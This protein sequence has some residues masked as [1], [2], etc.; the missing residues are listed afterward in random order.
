MSFEATNLFG[1]ISK[2]TAS[3]PSL[4]S[5]PSCFS[6]P[7]TLA[8]PASDLPPHPTD[9]ASP[10]NLRF[11]QLYTSPEYDRYRSQLIEPPPDALEAPA[12]RDDAKSP[13]PMD[14]SGHSFSPLVCAAVQEAKQVVWASTPAKDGLLSRPSLPLRSAV[15]VPVCSI[16]KEVVLLLMFSPAV[17]ELTEEAHR[18]LYTVAQAASDAVCGFLPASVASSLVTS[19]ARGPRSPLPDPT[20]PG[21]NNMPHTRTLIEAL[22]ASVTFQMVEMASEM[23]GVNVPIK[24]EFLE[25]FNSIYNPP[26][27]PLMPVAGEDGQ[28][29]EEG[30]DL[31]AFDSLPPLEDCFLPTELLE[32]GV[33]V[34]GLRD[35]EMTGEDWDFGAA[36]DF[37]F[38]KDQGGEELGVGTEGEWFGPGKGREGGEVLNWGMTE[39]GL[40]DRLSQHTEA[41]QPSGMDDNQSNVKQEEGGLQ[42]K[43]SDREQGEDSVIRFFYEDA[44]QRLRFEEFVKGFLSMSVFHTA[45]CWV[46]RGK[47]T[48]EQVYCATCLAD[49][50]SW[51]RFSSKLHGDTQRALPARVLVENQAIWER[52]A[53][54]LNPSGAGGAGMENGGGA[55][56]HVIQTA[57]GLPVHVDQSHRLVVIFYSTYSIEPAEIM[58]SFVKRAL[59]L[60]WNK[61]A[62]HAAALLAEQQ[63][64]QQQH[65]QLQHESSGG[66]SYSLGL[67]EASSSYSLGSELGEDMHTSWRTSNLDK[68]GNHDGRIQ[69]GQQQMSPLTT[70]FGGG[71]G[72]EREEISHLPQ[73]EGG[74]H[75]AGGLRS[76]QGSGQDQPQ[77][78]SSFSSMTEH[79]DMMGSSTSTYAFEGQQQ[80]RH[81]QQQQQQ[82]PVYVFGY[83]PQDSSSTSSSY[84]SSSTTSHPYHHHQAALSTT[85]PSSPFSGPSATSAFQRGS[86]TASLPPGGGA[87]GPGFGTPPPLTYTS[88]TPIL[89]THGGI[90]VPAPRP[91]GGQGSAGSQQQSSQQQQSQP[92]RPG[93][94]PSCWGAQGTDLGTVGG[95]GLTTLIHLPPGS[96]LPPLGGAINIGGTLYYPQHQVTG[97]QGAPHQQPPQHQQHPSS[98]GHGSHTGPGG[99]VSLHRED[100]GGTSNLDFSM[101]LPAGGNIAA[102]MMPPPASRSPSFAQAEHQ[103]PQSIRFAQSGR[104]GEKGSVLSVRHDGGGGEK[105]TRGETAMHLGGRKVS[106]ISPH[107]SGAQSEIG[108]GGLPRTPSDYEMHMGGPNEMGGAGGVTGRKICKTESCDQPTAKRSPYCSQH[109]G[110]RHCQHPGLGEREW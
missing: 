82:Q 8:S 54:R 36:L 64:E 108:C 13:V 75:G 99:G 3:L 17:L 55:G 81:P 27:P 97:L 57:F 5:L 72:Q 51:V 52:D 21:E 23:V 6:C 71:G 34:S 19:A 4:P 30:L 14:V 65:L 44:L 70:A 46:A 73:V 15:G 56:K 18:F 2:L 16:G 49:V 53:Q 95:Q 77:R 24:T 7:H 87:A 11:I 84:P 76:G 109:T 9:A 110:V 41:S 66:G 25:T 105:G 63:Q 98:F 68:T 85:T 26:P 38:D 101:D 80:Q 74:R 92:S 60:L 69:S 104:Q 67:S 45:E 103:A 102:S 93:S 88:S 83:T 86:T 106:S 20:A 96:S 31:D 62:Q 42:G 78:Q 50:Q 48:L 90:P 100:S 79:S 61:D 89:T 28:G 47:E 107:A 37:I 43:G 40:P 12:Q 94:Q 32:D 1:H 35:E 58:E 39:G 29:E 22:P 10:L 59:D 33:L 91:A